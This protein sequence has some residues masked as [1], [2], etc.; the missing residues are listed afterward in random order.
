M[1]ICN[2]CNQ[3]KSFSQFYVNRSSKDGYQR[4]CKEC[5]TNYL[6][7]RNFKPIYDGVL[8][9]CSTCLIEKDKSSFYPDKRQKNGLRP[10]CKNCCRNTVTIRKFNITIEQYNEMLEAQEHKCAICG[11]NKSNDTGTFPIDHCHIT[12]KV[13]GLLCSNCN[14]ALGLFKDSIVYLEQAIKYLRK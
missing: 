4:R 11:T 6:D 10:Q 7:T 12:Q 8:I 2:S 14:T 5:M 1:K 13:R 9:K 3:S